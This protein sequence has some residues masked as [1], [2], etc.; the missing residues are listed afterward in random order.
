MCGILPHSVEEDTGKDRDQADKAE[1]L[2]DAQLFAEQA[3]APRCA[4]A[5]DQPCDMA[6][7]VDPCV[8]KTVGQV[9]ADDDQHLHA[10]DLVEYL[11]MP[12]A[13]IEQRASRPKI[14]PDAP[15][16][17]ASDSA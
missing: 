15:T 14:A 17:A 13:E 9:D 6:E 1:D 10:E 7:V 12:R 4:E 11:L 3:G 2:P 8:Q 16:D 5:A